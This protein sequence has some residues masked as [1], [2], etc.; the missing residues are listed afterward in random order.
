MSYNWKH[1]VSSPILWPSVT[2]FEDPCKVPSIHT[3]SSGLTVANENYT[4]TEKAHSGP[5]DRLS[6]PSCFPDWEEG[7][8]CLEGEGA[9]H[10]VQVQ[11]LKH[12]S[13]PLSNDPWLGPVPTPAHI[14][15]IFA[16][17]RGSA[18]GRKGVSPHLIQ[19]Q[20]RWSPLVW[21][22]QVRPRSHVYQ[23]MGPLKQRT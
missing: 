10:N 1:I 11:R 15:S 6:F 4:W 18:Q 21:V 8:P 17:V 22:C 13:G 16:S 7:S 23:E 9:G 19:S 3:S 12:I 5:C 20:V 14:P 2:F